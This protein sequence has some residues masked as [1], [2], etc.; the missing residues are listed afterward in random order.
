MIIPGLTFVVCRSD[1]GNAG[2]IDLT[3]GLG[4]RLSLSNDLQ[5]VAGPGGAGAQAG[6]T[7]LS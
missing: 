6:G 5:L 3:V 7:R 2:N 4:G 1:G